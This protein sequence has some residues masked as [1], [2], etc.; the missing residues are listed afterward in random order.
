PQEFDSTKEDKK[1][2]FKIEINQLDNKALKFIRKAAEMNHIDE[3]F[4]PKFENGLGTE[5]EADMDC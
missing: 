3:V 5:K 2:E 4:E 1:I